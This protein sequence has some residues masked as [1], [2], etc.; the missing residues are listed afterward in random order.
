MTELLNDRLR[1]SLREAMRAKDAVAVAALR[2]ALAALG[3]AEAVPVVVT[4][5]P[6]TA[7]HERIA[8]TAVGVGAAEV[9]R[10]VLSA[11]QQRAVVQ[12]EVDERLI[13]ADEL[14]AGGQAERAVRLRAE[15]AVLTECLAAG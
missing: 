15:A 11:E 9:S 12:A 5:G 4:S 7:T 3:N 10:R 6:T 8:G 13:A 2:S 14:D 1:A